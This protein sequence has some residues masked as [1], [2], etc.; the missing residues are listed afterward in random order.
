MK[1]VTV[2][3]PIMYDATKVRITRLIKSTVEERTGSET[4]SVEESGTSSN[5]IEIIFFDFNLDS[6]EADLL[7]EDVGLAVRSVLTDSNLKINM[8]MHNTVT[9]R[10]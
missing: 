5:S 9:K 10:A 6:K 4:V 3:F 8:T 2:S 1:Q 7:L